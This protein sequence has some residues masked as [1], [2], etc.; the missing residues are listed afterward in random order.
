MKQTLETKAELPFRETGRKNL[1]PDLFLPGRRT[2]L[3]AM[4]IFVTSLFPLILSAAPA[5][6]APPPV[7]K[8]APVAVQAKAAPAV[9][10]PAIAPAVDASG[11]VGGELIRLQAP[12]PTP[13]TGPQ[14]AAP[15]PTTAPAT[16]PLDRAGIIDRAGKALETVKTAQGSFQQIDQGGA[17]RTGKFYIS[18][19]GKIRFEYVTPEPMFIISDGVSVSNYEPKRASYDAVALSAT[20]LALFLRSNVDLKRDGSVTK[21]E[22]ANG[23]YF[24]TLVDKTGKAEGEMILEFRASD[25]EL[26]GWRSIS[27]SG[28]ETKVRLSGTQT[29]VKLAPTLF[30]VKDPNDRG[31]EH[32]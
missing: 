31:D 25:F 27:G 7:V 32:R 9:L 17:T 4:S 13:Q 21:A 19:P 18:R 6:A 22:Y 12:A 2:S 26:L 29:N 23:S 1:G 16:A 5:H 20:P 15:A 30:V 11:P 3:P 8:P 28:E 10:A 24:V 14:A